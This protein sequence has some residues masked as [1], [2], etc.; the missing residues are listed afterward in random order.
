MTANQDLSNL[1]IE[2]ARQDVKALKKILTFLAIS[3]GAMALT[4]W[5]STLQQPLIDQ[6]DFRQTQTALTALF[7]KPGLLSLFNYETPVVG[8]P[9][10]IPFEFP[11]YQWI[12]SWAARWLPLSLSSTGRLI[13]MII[14]I[15]CLWPAAA[16]MRLY[17]IPKLATTLLALLY[18]TSSIYLY[19]NRSF[20]IESSALFLTLSSLYFYSKIRQSLAIRQAGHATALVLQPLLLCGILSLAL[21]VKATTALPAVALMSLDILCL[22]SLSARKPATERADLRPLWVAAAGIAIAFFAM[23]N[24]TA[25]A[26]SLKQLNSIGE[27]LTSKSLEQWNYGS[28][29][30]RISSDL[31][32]GVVMNRMLTPWGTIPAVALLALGFSAGD[33]GSRHRLFVGSCIFMAVVPMLAFPN[34]HIVHNY[35]QSANQI[36]LLMAIATATAVVLESKLSRF[37]RLGSLGLISIF[38]L[39]SLANFRGESRYWN[40]AFAS[41]NAKLAIGNIIQARTPTNSTLL[42]FDDDWSSA[43]AFHSQRRALTPPDWIPEIKLRRESLASDKKLLGGYPLGAVISRLAST[44]A[45]PSLN[46]ECM[47]TE[48]IKY[49][50]WKITLCNP[51]PDASQERSAPAR[52]M[53]P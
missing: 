16:I 24:W 17:Q 42:V 35:Y 22:L 38:I 2:N 46:D 20:M 18:F 12:V 37:L 3:A 15:A 40:D 5:L 11:L 52:P 41:S 10:A 28:I 9:W 19:W 1:A 31:W 8:S 14:G 48:T 29:E 6:H 32:T 47:S 45:I 23:H 30:Q 13:S 44:Q 25:H 34:L 21:L 51:L 36:Y 43:F 26:D 49:S 53:N 39:S 33:K 4:F 27:Y 7:M 50:E